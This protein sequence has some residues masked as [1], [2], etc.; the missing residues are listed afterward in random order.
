MVKL[1]AIRR[2]IAKKK[3]KE[4]AKRQVV[5]LTLE[6]VRA[7]KT[8]LRLLFCSLSWAAALT[9]TEDKDWRAKRLAKIAEASEIEC[10][11]VGHEQQTQD[12]AC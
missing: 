11:T 7:Y 5:S 10:D 3:E 6:E 8:A 9:I 12:Q 2:A 1:R 4:A